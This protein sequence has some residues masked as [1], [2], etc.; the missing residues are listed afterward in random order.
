MTKEQRELL[1]K[2]LDQNEDYLLKLYSNE[3]THD[4]LESY[5]G[6]LG[7]VSAI[8]VKELIRMDDNKRMSAIMAKELIRLDDEKRLAEKDI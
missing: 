1:A 8:I 3:M 2:A 7:R 4:D 6:L 5:I